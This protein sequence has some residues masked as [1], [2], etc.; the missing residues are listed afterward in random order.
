MYVSKIIRG[1]LTNSEKAK[2]I[3][4]LQDKQLIRKFCGVSPSK[5]L[6]LELAENNGLERFIEQKIRAMS[7]DKFID[8]LEK[9]NI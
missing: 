4:A 1:T 5:F 3:M 7:E 6:M 8:K 9:T 2:I